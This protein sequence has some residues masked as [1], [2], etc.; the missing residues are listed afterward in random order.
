MTIK[1]KEDVEPHKIEIDLSGPDGNAFALLGMAK[2]WARDLQLDWAPIR[3]E[4]MSGDYEHL[5]ETLDEHF[6]ELVDF[7][8]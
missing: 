5:L 1:D 3:D 2:S 8:R 7:I 6:G 4:A